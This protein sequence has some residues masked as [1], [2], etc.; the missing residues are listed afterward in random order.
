MA[1]KDDELRTLAGMLE[2]REDEHKQL[3]FEVRARASKVT[4]PS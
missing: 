4:L 3:M 1:R 2:K